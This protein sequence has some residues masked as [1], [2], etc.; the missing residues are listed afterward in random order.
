M[1]ASNFVTLNTEVYILRL[2]FVKNIDNA[3]AAHDLAIE[4]VRFERLQLHE[5]I[6][7]IQNNRFRFLKLLEFFRIDEGGRWI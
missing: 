4:I 3:V 5:P 7:A 2:H 1:L 6:V